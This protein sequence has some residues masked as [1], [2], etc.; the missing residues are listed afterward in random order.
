M[1]FFSEVKAKLGLDISEFERGMSKAQ[2]GVGSLG[3]QMGKQIAGTEKIGSTLATA[4]GVNLQSIAESVARFWIGSSK[5]AEAALEEQVKMS[6]AAA[7]RAEQ[8][9]A[10]A[11]EKNKALGDAVAK[12]DEKRREK[13]IGDERLLVELTDKK[14]AAMEKSMTTKEGS[15]SNLEA[16]K[17]VYEIEV[18]IG[19]VK[20]RI[21]KDEIAYNNK[22]KAIADAKLAAQ[23]EWFEKQKTLAAQLASDE[24][25]AG[26][27]LADMK[28]QEIYDSYTNEQKLQVLKGRGQKAQALAQETG[29][30]VDKLALAKLQAEYKALAKTIAE[31]RGGSSKAGRTGG[32]NSDLVTGSGEG[33]RT[34]NAKGQLMR[35]GVVVSREDAVRTQDTLGKNQD[36]ASKS[37]DQMIKTLE[38]IDKKLEPTS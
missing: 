6:E 17:A 37:E 15:T 38:S 30:N 19:E 7:V 26:K 14:N 3:K 11:K 32:D 34:M 29:L 24:N 2:Q 27:Q 33:D 5:E 12:L 25:A 18:Q 9:L 1:A 10:K 16:R 22:I 28:A 36:H 35:R 23:Q 31:A 8:N 20:E 21:S 4:L 13:A